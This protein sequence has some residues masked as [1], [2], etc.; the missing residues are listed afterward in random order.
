MQGGLFHSTEYDLFHE[1]TLYLQNIQ[2]SIRPKSFFLG[3]GISITS[4]K[5]FKPKKWNPMLFAI[6]SSFIFFNL[7]TPNE[8]DRV[9][10][11]A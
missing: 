6:K 4:K 10:K 3:F 7:A 9:M 8:V 11:I 5:V 2:V 1:Y